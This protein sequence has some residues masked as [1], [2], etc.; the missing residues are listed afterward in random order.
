MKIVIYITN[1]NIM[2]VVSNLLYIITLYYQRQTAKQKRYEGQRFV[3]AGFI[4][5][6]YAYVVPNVLNF[7]V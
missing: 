5:M 4:R 1:S 2:L 7:D 3:H 6:G